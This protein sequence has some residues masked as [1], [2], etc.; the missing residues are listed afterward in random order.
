MRGFWGLMRAYWFSERWREAWAL[1]IIIALLTAVAS[2]ASVWIAEAS[3]ELVNSIAFF[4]NPLNMS[5]L[6]TLLTNAGMLVLLV[7]IKDVA[8]VGVRHLFSSTL[9]RKWR[10]WLNSR[11]NKAL[12]DGNHT[13]FHVQHA[14]KGKDGLIAEAPD[15]I[16]QRV[17][18]S[19]K[20]M[21]G[22]AIGLAMGVLGVAT[23]LYFVGQKLI[24]TSTSVAGLEFFG[25]YGGAVLAFA[26]VA[27]YVPANTLIAMKL[28]GILERLTIAIQQAEGSYR[29]ELTTLLRRSFHVAAAGGENVQKEMHDRLYVG[30][31]R[32]W[33]RLNWINAGYMSFETIYNFVA[34]RIVAYGPGL[35]PYMHE[36]IDLKRY[37]TGAELVNSLISQCSWFIHVMPS[38]ATL[39]ANAKRITDLANAIENVQQPQEFYRLS[40]RSDFRYDVQHPVFGLT[41][42]RLELMHQGEDAAPF[43]SAGNIRFRRGEWTLIKGES[44][45]GKTS[46]IKAINGLW[47]YG[48]GDIVFPEGV[49][50]YYA[51]QDVKLQQVSLKRLVC[52]PDGDEAHADARVAAVLHKAGLGDFIEYLA[53]EDREGKIWDQVLSGGQKQKLMLARILLHQP[54]ILFLDEATGALDPDAKIAFHQAIK[55]N[56]AGITVISV[57]HEP[58]PPKAANG[59]SFYHS[60]LL[61]EDGIAMKTP[62]V[63]NPPMEVAAALVQPFPVDGARLR[64]ARIIRAKGKRPGLR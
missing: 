1:T 27:L 42:K 61:L 64:L 26:A 13:H 17:Q 29:A 14:A 7:M 12:L 22:G 52:L 47:P 49:R 23:S 50:S 9:H 40:G 59:A 6:A 39:N 8:F 63:A 18:D 51:A 30:I 34:A 28:G 21:T 19:I 11:F 41:V 32:T 58:E 46:L 10:G 44:G 2:K 48:Q 55:D 45:S 57:M 33:G 24:E 31:D 38:I 5:P 54:G 35:L 43:L 62:I 15:N 36:Q 60:I 37:I 53:A 20:Q 16:D 25:D 4:H 3:G 56:C